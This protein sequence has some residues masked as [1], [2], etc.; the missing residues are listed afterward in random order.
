MFS[1]WRRG[2]AEKV[3]TSPVVAAAPVTDDSL[4]AAQRVAPAVLAHVMNALRD[5]RGI[6]VESLFCALGGTAGHACQ[7]SVSAQARAAGKAADG[8]FD[9]AT[10]ADGGRYYFGDALNRPLAEDRL[11]VWS[12]LAGAASHAGAT[13][14]PDLNEIFAHNASVLGSAQFGL[15]RLPAEHPVHDTP[16][17]YARRIWPQVQPLISAAVPEPRFWPV[18]VALAIQDAM[19]QA[20]GVLPLELM[21][22]IAMESAIPVSKMP[23]TD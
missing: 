19:A 12:L 1:W 15:P 23:I 11:S 9:V 10:T 8:L 20:R 22:K 5:G 13:Q 3:R 17:S 6:H 16:I 14:L 2:R 4:L 7:A 21:V 18:A